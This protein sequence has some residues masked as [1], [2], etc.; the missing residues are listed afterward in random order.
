[1]FQF[2]SSPV[3]ES[4]AFCKIQEHSVPIAVPFYPL[5]GVIAWPVKVFKGT[6]QETTEI[7][8]SR[9]QKSKQ[10]KA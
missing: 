9:T 7:E 8:A 6:G 3:M 2:V 5:C 10:R 4:T 1:M